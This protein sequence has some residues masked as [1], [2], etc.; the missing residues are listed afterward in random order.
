MT[1]KIPEHCNNCLKLLNNIK[2]LQQEERESWMDTNGQDRNGSHLGN[3]EKS[4]PD[5]FFKSPR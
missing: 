4:R 5:I 1:P 2:K 3:L